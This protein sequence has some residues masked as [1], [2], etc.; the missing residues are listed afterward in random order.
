VFAVIDAATGPDVVLASSSSFIRPSVI[1]RACAHNPERVIVGHPFNPP[2]LIPLVEVVPAGNT[3]EA[4]VERAMAF[5]RGVGKRP[6]RLRK[7]LAGHVANR[8][9]S[10]LWREACWLVEQGVA[11]LADIDTAISCGPGLRWAVLG[12][13]ANL[14]LSGGTGG[15][16]HVLAQLGPGM[17]QIWRDLH[18]VTITPELAALLVSGVDEELADI[19]PGELGVRRD[20]VVNALLAE[21]SRLPAP[22]QRIRLAVSGD[23]V[24]AC[25]R[26]GWIEWNSVL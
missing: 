25:P 15:L 26:E 6:I 19:D 5:Y 8:L 10:A 11:G 14:H 9:Q 18:D 22:G 17:E 21:K 20:A 13:F 1:A 12:P 4:S 24:V 2:H 7:E 3:S 16:A 23:V